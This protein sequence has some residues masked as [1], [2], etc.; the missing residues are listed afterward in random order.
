MIDYL[1]AIV[2]YGLDLY[3]AFQCT[4]SAW[5]CTIIHSHHIHSITWILNQTALPNTPGVNPEDS[6]APRK[7]VRCCS[8]Q[9]LRLSKG[10]G[11]RWR[12]PALYRVYGSDPRAHVCTLLRYQPCRCLSVVWLMDWA[13]D[14]FGRLTIFL[15][16][17]CK[18]LRSVKKKKKRGKGGRKESVLLKMDAPAS[19]MAG[20]MQAR[21]RGITAAWAEHVHF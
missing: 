10:G 5:R 15:C 7:V 18:L 14:S 19:I 8:K 20:A 9:P 13:Q 6:R 4:S 17:G 3:T 12:P 21:V 1:S 16:M 11:L 2:M